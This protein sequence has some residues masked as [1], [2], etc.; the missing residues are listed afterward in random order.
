MQQ[1]GLIMQSE[2][3]ANLERFPTVWFHLS[4]I[5]DKI[6]EMELLVAKG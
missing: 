3:K 1:H 4:N 6:I 2:K 5:L